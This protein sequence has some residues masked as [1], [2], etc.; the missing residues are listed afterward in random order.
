MHDGY[1]VHA[2]LSNEHL[3]T[4][5]FRQQIQTNRGNNEKHTILAQISQPREAISDRTAEQVAK[6]DSEPTKRIVPSESNNMKPAGGV[7]VMR[8]M[9]LEFATAQE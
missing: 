2:Q 1:A 8:A 5:P 9:T 3:L 4:R 7:L 6:G